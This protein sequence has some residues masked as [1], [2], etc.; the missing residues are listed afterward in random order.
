MA[1]V[2][3][4]QLTRQRLGRNLKAN[5]WAG[6]VRPVVWTFASLPAGNIGDVLVCGRIRNGERVMQGREFHSAMGGTATGAYSTY[7]I[8]VDGN[9]LG[10]VITAGK[11]LAAIT[12][13]S[14]GQN[15]IV[16]TIAQNA[17]VEEGNTSNPV[18]SGLT[19]DVFL[20]CVNAGSAFATAGVVQ[21]YVLLVGD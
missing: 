5:E 14:A 20:C 6:K 13:V 18:G 9:S 15:E 21:G 17:L 8:G 7:A 1:T 4:D 12:F 3:S 19:N 10:A 2:Y 11:Y 16:S